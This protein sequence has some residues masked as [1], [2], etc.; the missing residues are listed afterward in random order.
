MNRSDAEAAVSEGDRSEPVC[1]TVIRMSDLCG[2]C[3]E[4]RGDSGIR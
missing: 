2:G 4:I 3:L 1:Y